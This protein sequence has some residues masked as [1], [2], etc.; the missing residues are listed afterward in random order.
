[1]NLAIVPLLR[2][3]ADIHIG[4]HNPTGYKVNAHE[5]APGQMFEIAGAGGALP[6][7]PIQVQH[8]RIAALAFRFGPVAYSPD[9]NAVPEE[10][11]AAL[12]GV[13]CW[14]VDTLR[15]TPHPT[16]ANVETALQ[17]IARVKPARA[18]LTNLHMD[19]DYEALTRE[20]PAGVEPAFD[21]MT[22]M[23]PI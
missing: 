18:I 8:G 11:F 10:A 15:Y 20:L 7:L 21:G 6:V 14:I 2:K 13:A 5:I 23:L 16:H 12:Q 4:P 1:M 3:N 9:V 22:I 19:L 17:W